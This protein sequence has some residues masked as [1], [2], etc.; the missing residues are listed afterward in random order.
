MLPLEIIG[1]RPFASAVVFYEGDQVLAGGL[2][3]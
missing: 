2:A 3:R 1:S